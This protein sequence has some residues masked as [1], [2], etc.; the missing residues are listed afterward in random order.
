MIL[1]TGVTGHVGR[2]LTQMLVDAGAQVRAVSRTPE[3]AA[4]PPSVEVVPN[5]DPPLDGVEAV[6]INLAALPEGP[7]KIVA[8]AKEAGVRRLVGLSSYSVLDDNPRN[9]IAVRHRELERV[10]VDSGLEWVLL[11]PAGGFATTALEW[12]DQIRERGVVRGPF[13]R[14]HSAPLH[15]KDIA[16]VA[17][18]ALLTDKLLGTRPMFSGPESVTYEERARLI[19]EALGREIVFEEISAEEAVEEWVRAGIPLGAARAR[20]HMF[21]QLV[22]RPHEISPLEPITG[23]RGRT[24]AQWAIDHVGDFR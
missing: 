1:V 23:K 19:G 11:R 14:A 20:I 8:R 24:F 10:V 7:E 17:A 15:E 18:L 21:A 22:D 5:T 3:K 4:L 12:R 16:E 9:A 2:P 6:F 13:A